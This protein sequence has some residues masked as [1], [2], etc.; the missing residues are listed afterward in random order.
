MHTLENGPSG[1]VQIC[2]WRDDRWHSGITF[3]KVM[4][5]VIVWLEAYEQHL[6][7][8]DSIASFVGTMAAP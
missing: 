6:S 3:D 8:G 1:A 5:K 7:T 4:L 2:H